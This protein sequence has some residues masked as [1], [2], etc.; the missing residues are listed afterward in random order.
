MSGGDLGEGGGAG[1]EEIGNTGRE[2]KNGKTVNR[3][4]LVPLATKKKKK[5][6][7][8]S[9]IFPKLSAMATVCVS[10]MLSWLFRH[11]ELS[12]SVTPPHTHTQK[13]AIAK[14]YFAFNVTVRPWLKGYECVLEQ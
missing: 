9:S 13:K 7:P 3:G 11:L 14:K 10:L 2:V 1:G 5:R 12:G 6:K 8:S 4:F